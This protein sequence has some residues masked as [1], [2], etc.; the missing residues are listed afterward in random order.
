VMTISD[1]NALS[2]V[3]SFAGSFATRAMT[4]YWIVCCWA[5]RES[6]DNTSPPPTLKMGNVYRIRYV[7]L[8]L[9]SGLYCAKF[10]DS[11]SMI[12]W[13]TRIYDAATG[14]VMCLIMNEKDKNISRCHLRVP[15]MYHPC[16]YSP[17]SYTHE[18][19]FE[20]EGS[21]LATLCILFI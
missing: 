5:P 13:A 4:Q 21:W 11:A 2:T 12:R 15:C 1:S 16:W 20:D 17:R 7:P 19:R 18:E 3:S 8:T 10:P 9:A 6:V 14:W